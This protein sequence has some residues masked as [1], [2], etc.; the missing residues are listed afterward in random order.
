MIG[1]PFCFLVALR[2]DAERNKKTR[3]LMHELETQQHEAKV[4]RLRT[5]KR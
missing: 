1:Y 4:E 2:R 5:K 3:L